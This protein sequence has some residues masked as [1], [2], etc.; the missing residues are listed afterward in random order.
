MLILIIIRKINKKENDFFGDKYASTYVIII[1]ICSLI[2]SL[3]L[4]NNKLV[5]Y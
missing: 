2:S 4:Y 5:Y 3:L 1:D